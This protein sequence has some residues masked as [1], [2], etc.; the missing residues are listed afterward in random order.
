M[1]SER[2]A[3]MTPM[4][5]AVT[6]DPR[7]ILVAWLL[8]I[9]VLVALAAVIARVV[10]LQVAPGDQL[11]GFVESRTST[12]TLGATRG[13]LL[14]RRGR[15]LATTRMGYRVVVDPEGLRLAM[16]R[17]NTLFDRIVVTLSGV[18]SESPNDFAPRIIERIVKNEAAA[19]NGSE[20]KTSVSRYLLIGEVL[21][22][23]QAPRD[24]HRARTHP[25]ADQ[26]RACR[27][28]GGEGCVPRRRHGTCRC[29]GRGEALRRPSSRRGW[30]ADLCA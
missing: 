27:R 13:D 4:P 18:L 21:N 8:R 26:P 10:Q 24:H 7:G 15:T 17:D 11:A 3:L 14:D 22:Q 23:E 29:R 1:S 5:S 16:Q 28:I 2:D 9:G 25:R 20:T 12:Q 6:I 19:N 30:L